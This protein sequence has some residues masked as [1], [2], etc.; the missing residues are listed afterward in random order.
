M[1]ITFV[2]QSC[3]PVLPSR[4]LLARRSRELCREVELV[5]RILHADDWVIGG[6]D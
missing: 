5:S 6:D 1:S 3:S 2:Y 4:S